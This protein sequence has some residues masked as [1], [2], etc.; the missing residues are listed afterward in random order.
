MLGWWCRFLRWENLGEVCVCFSMLSNRAFL[1]HVKYEMSVT[2][3]PT[4]VLT[5]ILVL[6]LVI[7]PPGSSQSCSGVIRQ[8]PRDIG[9]IFTWALA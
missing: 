5:P 8:F 1:G 7:H 6:H 3:V 9:M 2:N 4:T